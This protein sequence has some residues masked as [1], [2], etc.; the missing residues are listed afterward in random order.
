MMNGPHPPG[1]RSTA[2][3][4]CDVVTSAGAFFAVNGLLTAPEP[5]TWAGL[6]IALPAT[7]AWPLALAHQAAPWRSTLHRTRE[8][9]VH[10]GRSGILPLGLLAAGAA[11]GLPLLSL[12]FVVA[13][14][15]AQFVLFAA[16][17][18]LGE[19][20]H[21]ADQ[22]VE[23]RF[24]LVVG[25]GPRAVALKRTIEM[26][27]SW[28][29]Q[30]VG[31]LDDADVPIS[32]EI[33]ES[34]MRKLVDIRELLREVVIDEI[35]FA[36]PRAM[37]SNLTPVLAAAAEAG[38]PFSIL[39]DLFGDCAV[40]PRFS[41]V[42]SVSTL[43]FTAAP[44]GASLFLKRTFDLVAGSVLMTLA[45][46]IV[47]AAAIAIVATSK[48]PIFFRQT[49]CGLHG[50]RFQML[51]LR[52]MAVDAEQQ[53]DHLAHLNELSGPAFKIKDD[54]RVTS[55]GMWL[56]RFSIDELPQLWNV[57]RGEMSLVGPRPPI[58]REVAQYSTS[59][60]RR[61]AM[62]P[63]LTGAWQV[64]GRSRMRDFADWVKLDLEYIDNWSFALDLKI[65]M[66]T[67]PAVVNGTGE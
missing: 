20:I 5:P 21:R 22:A 50:R 12:G 2:T 17:R 6:A 45:A 55:V 28:G 16:W 26:H 15:A 53:L 43:R 7:L 36:G 56:R 57:V 8:T 13:F 10:V 39:S 19:R 60:Q 32:H 47:G 14:G 62:R 25:S 52:T 30:I 24:L 37:L 48:G 54:P 18:L 67:I 44:S 65:L 64:S 34:A 1:I 33:P 3:L 31:Y 49:R 35:V 63:G 59:Y 9:F 41:S 23:E 11:F 4:A 61:L 58:P 38:I 29:L 40:P 46:P 66:R 51:K 42:G 27:P